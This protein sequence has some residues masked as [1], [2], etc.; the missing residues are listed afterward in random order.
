MFVAAI[1][2]GLTTSAPQS[3]AKSSKDAAAPEVEPEEDGDMEEEGEEE[4]P[5]ESDKAVA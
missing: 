2:A 5:K 3:G 4:E 1:N